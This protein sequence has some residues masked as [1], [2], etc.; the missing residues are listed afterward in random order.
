[1]TQVIDREA[2]KIP[3]EKI[4]ESLHNAGLVR[5]WNLLEIWTSYCHKD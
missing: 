3:R 2:D 5:R 4:Y 1:M